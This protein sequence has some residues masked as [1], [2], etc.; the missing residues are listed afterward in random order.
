M[1]ER[2]E[3]W[4]ILSHDVERTLKE[5]LSRKIGLE[6]LSVHK[7]DLEDLFI[8]LTGSSLRS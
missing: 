3:V 1:T 2:E 5:L 6:G 7:P 4:D 8:K